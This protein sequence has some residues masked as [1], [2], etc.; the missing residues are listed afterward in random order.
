MKPNEKLIDA[1]AD[2]LTRLLRFEHPADG[3]LSAYFREQRALQERQLDLE[4]VLHG[5]GLRA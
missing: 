2:V 4:R 1:T 3:V 5:M